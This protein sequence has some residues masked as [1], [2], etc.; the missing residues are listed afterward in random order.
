MSESRSCASS[1]GRT[2]CLPEGTKK[3]KEKDARTDSSDSKK[4]SNS[5]SINKTR[6]TD[7]R[8]ELIAADPTIQMWGYEDFETF[9]KSDTTGVWTK[10]VE[11]NF[12]SSKYPKIEDGDDRARER[13]RRMRVERVERF[14]ALRWP[15]NPDG[16]V[17]MPGEL[18]KGKVTPN[19]ELT[20]TRCALIGWKVD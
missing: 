4:D 17:I 11:I 2:S 6:P 16:E 14:I 9:R 1:H 18:E 10:I 12:P 13:A 5:N 7:C 19:G 8:G 15:R 3:E 20:S